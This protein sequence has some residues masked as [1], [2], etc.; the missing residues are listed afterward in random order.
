EAPRNAIEETLVRIWSEVLGVDKIGINDSFFELGGDSIK[1]IRIISKLN[2]SRYILDVKDLFNNPNIRD[3]SN[4][5]SIDL[6][7]NLI[8][9]EDIVG[10]ADL[11]PIQSW[12]FNQNFKE[13][14]QWNQ[15]VMLFKKDGFEEIIINKVFNK[16]LKQHDALRM[17]FKKS[18]DKI[19][20][21]NRESKEGLFELKIF[22]YL[23]EV[24]FKDKIKEECEVLQKSLNIWD[25][26]LIKLGLFKTNEGDYLAIIIH[27]L[28]VDG[29]SWRILFEDFQLGYKQSLNKEEI[30]IQEK[31]NSYLEWQ[32]A[33]EYYAYSKDLLSEV[34]YWSKIENVEDKELPIDREIN[35]E[36]RI[37]KHNKSIKL[38]IDEEYT[39]NLLKKV[40]K[41]Y[42]TSI[43]DILLIA[44]ALSIEKW[45]GN[46]NVIIN[47]ENHGRENI[48]AT[49]LNVNRTVG[50]FTSEYP[51]D[52]RID[53][54][55]DIGYNLKS[56]K[57]TLRKIPN[58]GIGYNILK[59][60]RDDI[61]VSNV[62]PQI[63]F[64]YLGDFNNDSNNDIFQI[65]ELS[66][67]NAVSKDSHMLYKIDINAVINNGVLVFAF[68]YNSYEFNDDNV[69]E[70]VQKYKECLYNLINHCINKKQTEMTPSDVSNY[71]VSIEQL[72]MYEKNTINLKEEDE[73]E[74]LQY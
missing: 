26:E 1:A 46:N 59:Y 42:N 18:N 38:S 35:I 74:N 22:N 61:F 13:M 64:N 29:I 65:S 23:S 52:L 67:G 4:Y 25:G 69:N 44:L 16:I 49:N 6:Q 48:G 47:M 73:F 31:T 7:N 36:K 68:G 43:D 33:I 9:Q 45:T 55:K 21:F 34:D 71:N 32:K 70:F 66:T 50:W 5:V 62:K 51:V 41:A 60:Y 30:V 27:H 24:H 14:N 54:N 11:T 8:N 58:K 10:Q 3:V 12:F 72:E 17:I 19:V 2:K 15:S 20:Q 57:E 53:T 37:V 39:E 28:V 56:I 40:N 63:S